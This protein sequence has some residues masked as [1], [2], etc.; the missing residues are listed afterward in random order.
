MPM[1]LR[2]ISLDSLGRKLAVWYWIGVLGM[3][4][5]GGELGLRI[6][7]YCFWLLVEISWG[8]FLGYEGDL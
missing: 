2:S 3:G 7:G 4:E 6:V 5:T 1:M 8:G